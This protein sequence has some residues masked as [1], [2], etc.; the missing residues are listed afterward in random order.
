MARSRLQ[1]TPLHRGL[2]LPGKRNLPGQVACCLKP[3]LNLGARPISRFPCVFKSSNAQ[4]YVAAKAEILS[5]TFSL[6]SPAGYVHYTGSHS[7]PQGTR[8]TIWP[9]S[10][11]IYLLDTAFEMCVP[12]RRSESTRVERTDPGVNPEMIWT[13]AS[14]GVA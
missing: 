12:A 14:A 10:R 2:T 11:A 4:R 3:E 7:I 5:P 9:Q 6:S 1:V 8:L 13:A